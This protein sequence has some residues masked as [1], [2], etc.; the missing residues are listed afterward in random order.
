MPCKKPRLVWHIY[1]YVCM[2][3]PVV[4]LGHA[5]LDLDDMAL[6]FLFTVII[7]L[8]LLSSCFEDGE[9]EGPPRT[10]ERSPGRQLPEKLHRE[11]CD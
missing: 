6:L 9:H 2:F 7:V 3:F 5:E 4:C 10:R 11:A 1:E 8:C